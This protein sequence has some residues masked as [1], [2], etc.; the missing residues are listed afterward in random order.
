[1]VVAVD[2]AG[3]GYLKASWDV[4]FPAT[5]LALPQ[6]LEGSAGLPLDFDGY[7]KRRRD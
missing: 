7:E 5:L 6:C 1:V 4:S 3:H 2:A